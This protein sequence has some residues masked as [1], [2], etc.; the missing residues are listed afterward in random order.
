[1][2]F[3]KLKQKIYKICQ[4]Y[5]LVLQTGLVYKIYILKLIP[6]AQT[7]STPFRL[8]KRDPKS[9]LHQITKTISPIYLAL[10]QQNVNKDKTYEAPSHAPINTATLVKKSH[11]KR[12]IMYGK[13]K[14]SPEKKLSPPLVR[15]PVKS[16]T[17]SGKNYI[18]YILIILIYY[19]RY[20]P[21]TL[22]LQSI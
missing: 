6:G 9:A 7:E 17:S 3:F 2:H 22:I 1:M 8:Q 11:P 13:E 14:E 20:T 18:T 5:F 12:D 16:P 15:S 10:E 4:N 19:G 21:S